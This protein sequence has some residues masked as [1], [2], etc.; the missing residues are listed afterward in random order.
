MTLALFDF[1]GTLTR[2]DSFP[3][4]LTFMLGTSGF[5]KALIWASPTIIA[6][7]CGRATN[8]QAKEALLSAAL[9]GKSQSSIE[10]AG[11]EFAEQC[12]PNLLR[13]QAEALLQK[14]KELGHET[15]L[16]SASPDAWM[17]PIAKQLGIK[18]ISSRLAYKEGI[19]LGK[20]EGKNCYG[21]EKVERIKQELTL[22]QYTCIYAY[23]DSRGD[24][25]MLE[26]ASHPRYKTLILPES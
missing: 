17:I 20:L 6:W 16:V 11:K 5:A 12:L 10:Q 13:P 7:K 4:F 18:L 1:D 25:E 8:Q 21:Q 14:H 23:G 24:K 3:A 19:F 9:K 22:D 26:L 2:K 15:L